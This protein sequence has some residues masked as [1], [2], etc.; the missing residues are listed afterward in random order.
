MREAVGLTSSLFTKKSYSYQIEISMIEAHLNISSKCT[1]GMS[2]VPLCFFVIKIAQNLCERRKDVMWYEWKRR[3]IKTQK[4]TNQMKWTNMCC[5]WFSSN[6][7]SLIRA[8]NMQLL[9]T[10]NK[11][12]RLPH[13]V[14]EHFCGWF[15]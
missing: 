2:S 3:A 11:A 14:A 7:L 12:H 9:K 6:G 8:C 10:H 5:R 15:R 1:F 13:D 4:K